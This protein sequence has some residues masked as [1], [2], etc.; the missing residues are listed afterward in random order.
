[1]ND[2]FLGI[3]EFKNEILE[4]V[5]TKIVSRT[6]L[7]ENSEFIDAIIF[8]LFGEYLKGA[9]IKLLSNT[10]EYFFFNMFEFK[11]SLINSLEILDSENFI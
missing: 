9:R 10:L 8:D 2:D 11:P 6:Y 4:E 7:Y 1:M 3:E 5:S